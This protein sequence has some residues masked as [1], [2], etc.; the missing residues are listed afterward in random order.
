METSCNKTQESE[1]FNR[2]TMKYVIKHDNVQR[3]LDLLEQ[4]CSQV[5]YSTNM[6]NTQSISSLYFDDANHNSYLSR[7]QKTNN[8]DLMRVRTYNS[9]DS[10]LYFEIKT[11][12]SLSH[13]NNPIKE[14]LLMSQKDVKDIVARRTINTNVDMVD[15]ISYMLHTRNV[16]PQ[17]IIS[18]NRTVYEKDQARIT[19]DTDICGQKS[20][21]S[22]ILENLTINNNKSIFN[23]NC[24]II[25]IKTK[26]CNAEELFIVQALRKKELIHPISNFSKF[27]AVYYYFFS[28]Y[29]Q[30]KPY[31]FNEII[32]NAHSYNAINTFPI[33]LKPN[34]FTSLEA[35]FYRIFNIIIG[36]PITLMKYSELTEH[37]PFLLKPNILKH[38]LI[39]CLVLNL[40]TFC[41]VKNRLLNKTINFIGTVFPLLVTLI[42]IFSLLF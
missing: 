30:R 34:T 29:L 11:N 24:A 28:K 12:N 33:M 26:D 41:K 6:S 9:D 37:K 21:S 22:N 14:R 25:E 4:H 32:G 35:L 40:L 17:V 10:K 7:V 3:V 8:F 15:R 23:L 20:I 5:K 2:K 42:F 27:V 38:Y 39:C 36:I 18:Y 13:Q 16:L 19:V 1:I 31:W